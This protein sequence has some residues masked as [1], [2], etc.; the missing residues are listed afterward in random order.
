MRGVMRLDNELFVKAMNEIVVTGYERKKQTQFRAAPVQRK[1]GLHAHMVLRPEITTKFTAGYCLR[2]CVLSHMYE[3]SPITHTP[4]HILWFERGWILHG[5]WQEIYYAAGVAVD[6]GQGASLDLE[7]TDPHTLLRFSPDA[8]VR[9]PRWG[10]H[11]I[12]IKG[13]NKKKYAE[14]MKAETIPTDAH[15]QVQ[16]YMRML[17][18]NKGMV[19]VECKDTNEFSIWRAERDDAEVEAPMQRL[20]EITTGIETYVAR[21]VLPTRICS[22]PNDPRAR[23]C[24]QCRACFGTQEVREK[25]LLPVVERWHEKTPEKKTA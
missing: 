5:W 19:L 18:M 6:L 4:Q 12:E 22:S 7:Y 25:L 24:E 1:M 8:I 3:P 17:N 20:A 10:V 16:L 9:L 11:V 21:D 23:S 14:L 15:R 2:E 13:Y